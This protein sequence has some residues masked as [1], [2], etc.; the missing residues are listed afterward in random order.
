MIRRWLVRIGKTFAW[1]IA[2]V[3]VLV[4]IQL[5]VSTAFWLTRYNDSVTLPNGMI[6][7][8]EFDFQWT[9]RGDLYAADGGTLL[10]RDV[11]FVCFDDRYVQAGRLFDAETGGPVAFEDRPEI[12]EGHGLRAG[13]G[14]CNGYYTGMLGPGLLYDGLEAPFLPPCEWRNFDN[15]TLKDRA[16]LNR[17][18]E[19]DDDRK[20][21]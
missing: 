12:N 20:R 1:S 6:L 2:V 16:W 19:Y 17:P 5:C 10:A 15:P 18:C 9:E 3:V 14:G 7:R 8:R 13:R 4:F 21:P 11:E